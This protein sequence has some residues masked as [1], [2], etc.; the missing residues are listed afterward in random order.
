MSH[1]NCK[2]FCVSRRMQS[3]LV[4]GLV[5]F[6]HYHLLACTGVAAIFILHGAGETTDSAIHNLPHNAEASHLRS[7]SHLRKLIRLGTT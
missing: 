3:P 7:D 6:S 2:N 5:N 1:R 4:V